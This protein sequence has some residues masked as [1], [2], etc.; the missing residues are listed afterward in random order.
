MKPIFIILALCA[1]NFVYGQKQTGESVKIKDKRIYLIFENNKLEFFTAQIKPD[2][3]EVL[4]TNTTF[5]LT[6]NSSN[7]FLKW[8]NPLRYKISWTDTTLIDQRDQALKDYFTS[9]SGQFGGSVTGLNKNSTMQFMADIAVQK[10]VPTPS[11]QPQPPDLVIPKFNSYQLTSLYIQLKKGN[12]GLLNGTDI[13][14]I[15]AFTDNLKAL[16]Q[17][18]TTNLPQKATADFQGMFNA[19]DPGRVSTIDD[20]VQ[21]DVDQWQSDFKTITDLVSKTSTLLASLKISNSD[22]ANL[23]NTGILSF[24]E[25]VNTQLTANKKIVANLTPLIAIMKKS[26]STDDQSTDFPGF[27]KVRNESFVD[28]KMIKSKLSLSEYQFNADTY[29]FSKKSD[30]VSLSLNFQKYDKT[31]F[32]VSTGVFYGSATLKSFGVS[33]AGTQFTVT[34]ADVKSNTAVTALFGNF[35]FADSRYF[36]PIVQFGIDPTKKSPFLLAGG[37]VVISSSSFAI[38]VGP[39]WSWD[40]TLQKLSVGQTITST[41]Q[42]TSD[43]KYSFD[44]APKGY[45]VGIQYNF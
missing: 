1:I 11:G 19:T 34:E 2:G 40:Q 5:L 33:N 13:V 24:I 37:G 22:V 6:D 30:V 42:L 3:K 18:N 9:L 43:I 39:I 27:F 4:T 35:S 44:V 10:T 28:G 14:A 38:S 21:S 36:S 41:T 15:N 20:Q 29:D 17:N 12:I 45:Y 7:I 31:R 25:K 8:T 32:F 16:D 23:F 26:I